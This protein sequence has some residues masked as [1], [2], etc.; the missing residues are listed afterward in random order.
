MKFKVSGGLFDEHVIIIAESEEE[1]AE[2]YA[3]HSGTAYDGSSFFMVP[4]MNAFREICEKLVTAAPEQ[5]R[6]SGTQEAH[7][8]EVLRFID[9]A[10]RKIDLGDAEAAA[11]FAFNAG[12]KFEQM[13]LKFSFEQAAET[14]SKTR[15]YLGDLRAKQ[16]SA[17]KEAVERR[18]KAVGKLMLRTRLSGGALDKWIKDRL[19]KEYEI[20]VKERTIRGDRKALKN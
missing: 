2:L 17:A 8:A 20:R 7:A 5:A 4:R 16:N 6:A 1:K 12:W 18:R 11:E 9:E 13:R 19:E 15:N 10:Q 3:A 14:G